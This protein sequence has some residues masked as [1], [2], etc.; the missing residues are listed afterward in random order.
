MKME[1]NP[2]YFVRHARGR[3]VHRPIL[4]VL[5][6]LQSITTSAAHRQPRTNLIDTYIN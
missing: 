4:A 2:L 6:S 5:Q 1:R 3:R